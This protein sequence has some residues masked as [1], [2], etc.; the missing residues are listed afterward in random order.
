MMWN[1]FPNTRI[2]FGNVECFQKRQLCKFCAM[3]INQGTFRFSKTIFV[4]YL[5]RIQVNYSY[6]WIKNNCTHT[7]ICIISLACWN[8]QC[9]ARGRGQIANSPTKEEATVANFLDSIHVG[10]PGVAFESKP[11]REDHS[12]SPPHASKG[13]TTPSLIE[14]V[15]SPR[16]DTIITSSDLQQ[17]PSN[18]E[19]EDAGEES[20]IVKRRERSLKWRPRC[21]ISPPTTLKPKPECNQNPA[22]IRQT[23]IAICTVQNAQANYAHQDVRFRE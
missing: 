13:K 12:L 3:V 23:Q 5:H 21:A 6:E 19:R 17:P 20:W 1:M 18:A 15:E 7:P 10:R 14:A 9:V 8:L 16:M 2:R 22:S 4:I 11:L